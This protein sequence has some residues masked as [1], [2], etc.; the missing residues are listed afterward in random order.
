MLV[1]RWL[2]RSKPKVCRFANSVEAVIFFF[3]SMTSLLDYVARVLNS[4]QEFYCR[5]TKGIDKG[6]EW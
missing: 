3:G 4:Y 6:I 5:M 2:G 1:F